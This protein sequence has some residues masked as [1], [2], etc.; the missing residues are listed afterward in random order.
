M[1]RQSESL[2][3]PIKS[4]IKIVPQ[5]LLPY[6]YDQCD[7]L[8]GTCHFGPY[9]GLSTIPGGIVSMNL[10]LVKSLLKAIFLH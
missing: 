9:K 10:F 7:F 6:A 2:L 4:G 5:F 3:P 1:K 8:L